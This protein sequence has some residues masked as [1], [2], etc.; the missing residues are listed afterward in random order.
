MV[1]GRGVGENRAAP[2]AATGRRRPA[3]KGGE[4]ACARLAGEVLAAARAREGEAVAVPWMDVIC[5]DSRTKKKEKKENRQPKR[6]MG[7]RHAAT[8]QGFQLAHDETALMAVHIFFSV[9]YPMTTYPS[10]Q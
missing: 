9:A 2:P 8:T 3:R 1:A 4:R 7:G 6:G 5:K 10:V